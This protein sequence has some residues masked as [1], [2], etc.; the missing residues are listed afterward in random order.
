MPA[1]AVYLLREN[2]NTL[3]LQPGTGFDVLLAL[4]A[5][6]GHVTTPIDEPLIF[7]LLSGPYAEYSHQ[8]LQHPKLSL[9]PRPSRS[10]LRSAKQR[11][12][13]IQFALSRGFRPV[14]SGAFSLTEEYSLTIEALREAYKKLEAGGL[15]VMTHWL[16]TP[17]SESVRAWATLLAS[18]HASGVNQP[19][20]QLIA[21][22][23]MRTATMIA[24]NQAFT[25]EELSIVRDFLQ[26]NALDPI[27]LPDLDPSELNRFNQLPVDIYHELYTA[28]LKNAASVI[29]DY[30]FNIRP[31]TDDRPFFF[32]FFRWRQTPAVIAGLGLTWQPF[33]GSGYLVLLALLG[34]M[35]FLAMPLILIPLL[36]F[37]RNPNFS[38]P[39]KSVIGYFACLGV[40]YLLIEIPLIQRFTLL[41][42][43]PA[44]SLAIVLFTLLLAS[45]A[46]SFFS[47]RI[48][49]RIA[50][51]ILIPVLALTTIVLPLMINT[52][53]PWRLPARAA[54]AILFLI[55]AG[56]L[57]GVP[58][59]VGL[60][61]LESQ[62]PGAIPWAWGINGAFSGVSGVLA[63]MI[64]L[65]AGLAAT[66]L[67]GAV[68]YLGAYLTAPRQISVVSRQ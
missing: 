31:P 44:L 58:F 28:L 26:Q 46:G 33:G 42:D 59:A 3:I 50:L 8:I 51:G 14:T 18:L 34:L 24:T 39:N 13:V 63:A 37:K 32:H 52:A 25:S 60:R 27:Y 61:N 45:G 7:D 65:D 15:L 54:I 20:S 40:G 2:A 64:S 49:L 53:L 47:P 30:D 6:A 11:Y 17:P 55:P 62:S 57:M 9:I 10:T 36:L 66:M 19:G 56:F 12:D 67:V 5:G 23:G 68:A 29:A 1:T 4:A 41:L 22:R 16:G 38:L 48:P 43:R 35:L 21:Y